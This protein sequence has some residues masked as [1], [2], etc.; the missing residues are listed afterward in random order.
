MCLSNVYLDKREE[1]RLLIEEVE[2]L[3]SDDEGVRVRAL[4]GGS[5]AMKGYY[6][7]EV[8]LMENYVILQKRQAA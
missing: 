8:N 4:L 1:D 5:R 6:I 2:H 7:H 3:I